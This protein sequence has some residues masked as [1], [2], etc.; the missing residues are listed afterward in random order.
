MFQN[1][2]LIFSN[3]KHCNLRFDTALATSH[4]SS[5]DGTGITLADQKARFKVWSAN[6]GAHRTGT[7]SLE[8]KLRDASNILKTV[9]D[10]LENL[11]QLLSDYTALASGE[12]IPWDQISE[13]DNEHNQ[14]GYEE[15]EEDLPE[16]E[17]GEIK[18]YIQDAVDNLLGMTMTIKNPAEHDRFMAADLTDMSFHEPHDIK[19]V[20]DKHKSLEPWQVERLGRAITRRR[21]YF[22]YRRSHHE[23]PSV[24]VDKAQNDEAAKSAPSAVVTFWPSL[25]KL[26]EQDS[27]HSQGEVKSQ[28]SL[29]TSALPREPGRIP[30]LPNK[31]I[32]GPFECP[33]C[34]CLIV[35]KDETEWK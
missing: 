13:T 2:K 19:Y 3:I 32:H 33:L 18:L 7:A 34:F 35:V 31:A 30:P 15:D 1:E 14:L 11:Q 12:T 8:Y 26:E 9:S 17:L 22:R 28:T 20:R 25:V 24:V 23:Q 4:D 5:R 29:A 10:Q 16:T 21:Q 27:L 6:I